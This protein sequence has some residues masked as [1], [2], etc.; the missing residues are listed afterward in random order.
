MWV[1]KIFQ[2][3][4][5]KGEFALLIHD[6]KLHDHEYF[7]KHFRMTPTR[8]EHLLSLIA[9]SITKNS[10]RREAIGASERLTVT[11]KFIFSGTSQVDLSAMFRIS[12]TAIGRII[13]ETSKAIWDV[14]FREGY[15]QCPQSENEWKQIASEF[16]RKWNFP[17]CIAAIDGK[18][19]VMQAP[20][21]SG[22]YFINYKKTFSIVFMG[23]CNAN[24]EF[25]LV[26]IGD[27][28]RNSDGGVLAN[29]DIGWA[30]ETN[31][32]NIPG[33]EEIPHTGMAFP[34]VLVA[35]EAFPLKTNIMKPY[36]QEILQIKERIFNYRLSRARRII[37]NSFGILAARC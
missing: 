6:L 17:H 34:Y 9:P 30:L 28:G 10:L 33:S 32:L 8:Y 3:R 7:F 13:N 36:P 21:R 2:E 12:P 25:I 11:L 26:D 24:Y 20:F 35:D 27:T 18:H 29:S 5:T 14:L 15:L 22:S 23:G 16:E 1:R 19:I 37:E 4:S 31:S